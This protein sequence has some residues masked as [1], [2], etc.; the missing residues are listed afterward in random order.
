MPCMIGQLEHAER[1]AYLVST[2]VFIIGRI[3]G[4]LT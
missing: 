1:Y 3:H 2:Y 4:Q